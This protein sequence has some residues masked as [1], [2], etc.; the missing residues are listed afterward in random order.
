[1]HFYMHK[2]VQKSLTFAIQHFCA[3]WQKRSSNL[4]DSHVCYVYISFDWKVLKNSRENISVRS[5]TNIFLI[6]RIRT[7]NIY[8]SYFYYICVQLVC[9][10][11][12]QKHLLLL[13]SVCTINLHWMQWKT[14]FQLYQY[15]ARNL[16][17][18]L[19]SFI[20]MEN[21]KKKKSFKSQKFFQVLL[22]ISKFLLVSG[23]CLAYTVISS[24]IFSL[25]CTSFWLSHHH[26]I[27][28]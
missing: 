12:M 2:T 5:M 21:K 18:R 19:Y 11:L 25:R 7:K 4:Q 14:T 13:F 20:C 16:D 26:P 17:V 3:H 10:N 27:R 8:T 28:K 1:M 15:Q 9:V 22:I 23:I 6:K 24:E